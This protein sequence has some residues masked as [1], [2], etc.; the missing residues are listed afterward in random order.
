[1]SGGLST[2]SHN[3][4][5]RRRPASSAAQDHRPLSSCFA[6]DTPSTDMR[7]P[8]AS[9]TTVLVQISLEVIGIVITVNVTSEECTTSI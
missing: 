1:M 3:A 2:V 4:L 9:S 6:P 5:Q 7:R 8:S